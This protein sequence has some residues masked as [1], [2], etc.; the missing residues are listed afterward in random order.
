MMIELRI[1]GETMLDLSWPGSLNHIKPSDWQDLIENFLIKQDQLWK[2][3][4]QKGRSSYEPYSGP[5]K[6]IGE[7]HE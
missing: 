5:L 4:F 7:N 6:G 2:D 1:N 3:S